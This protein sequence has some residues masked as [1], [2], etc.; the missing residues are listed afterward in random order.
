MPS[1]VYRDE[2]FSYHYVA[3]TESIEAKNLSAIESFLRKKG[4]PYSAGRCWTTAAFYKETKAERTKRQKEGRQA[5]KMEC[6]SCQA[7]Y[8][9]HG[10]DFL[11]FLCQK[12]A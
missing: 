6:A 5:L 9:F 12:S 11:S 10:W 4:M 1:E 3:P 2:G 7:V 8:D